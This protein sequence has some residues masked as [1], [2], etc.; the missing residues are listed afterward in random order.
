M[1]CGNWSILR[2]AGLIQLYANTKR[3]H[4]SWI[5]Y[6]LSNPYLGKAS[7]CTL[8]A[9]DHTENKPLVK[10]HKT[11]ESKCLM[12]L[13]NSIFTS[14]DIIFLYFKTYKNGGDTQGCPSRNLAGLPL[15]V[16]VPCMVPWFYY[17]HSWQASSLG[18]LLNHI[19]KCPRSTKE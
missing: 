10:W 17:F 15:W 7:P 9:M 19:A 3:P 13:V 5:S 6:Q 16:R 1:E 12:C 14:W 18:G 8:F 11:C 2:I 4:L